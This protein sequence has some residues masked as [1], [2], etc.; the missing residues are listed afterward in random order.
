MQDKILKLLS[1]RYFL[2][3]EKT[4]DDIAKRISA[5]YPES[6]EYIKNMEFI[7]SSPTIM[8]LNT[9][10]ERKGTLSSC[11]PMDIEDSIE[12]IMEAMKECALVT[13]AGGGCGYPWSKL[14]GHIELVKGVNANSS[15]VLPF[16]QIFDSVLDGIL[17]G[18]KRRG[19]GSSLLSIYH[20]DILKFIDAKKDIKKFNRSNFSIDI[21]DL[22]YKILKNNPDKTFKIRTVVDEKEYDLKDENGKIYSYKDLW[23]K[24]I[25]SAW[26]CAEPGIFNGSIAFNRCTCTNINKMVVP[27]PCFEFCH[28][29]Y[30]SCNLGS[31]NVSKLVTVN[32]FVNFD[33]DKFKKIIDMA[34]VYLNK[35]I[36]NNTFPIDKIKDVT[37]KSRPIGL[38]L[39]GLSHLFY[40][41][42]ISYDSEK[43]EDFTK[44]MIRYMTLESMLVSVEKAKNKGKAYEYFDYN[45]FMSANERFFTKDKCREIDVEQLKRDI[46]KYGCY[47]SSQTSIAPTGSISF[48]AD[49]SSGIEPVFAL[50]YTRKIEK[51][52][53]EYEIVTICDSIFEE[54][55]T[56]NYLH[57]KDKILEYVSKNNGSCKGCNEL[58]KSVQDIFV[59]AGNIDKEWHLKILAAVANNVSLSV[60]KTI[61]LPSDATK[62]QIADIYIKAH[63]MGIIGVTVYRDGCREGILNHI[64]GGI[65]PESV[66]RHN[67][68]K[69]PEKL[70]CD[71]HEIRVEGEQYLVMVGFLNG[72][73]YEMFVTKD[74]KF[75]KL[76]GHTTGIIKKIKDKNKKDKMTYYNLIVNDSEKDEEKTV[77]KN[78][79]KVSKSIYGSLSRAISTELR[80][81][82]PL[83]I[84]VDQLNK[85][86]GFTEFD[87]IVSRILK[88][89]I[90]EGEEVLT[91][92]VCPECGGKLRYHDGCK[93][94]PCGWWKCG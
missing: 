24:I 31:I 37:K 78:I 60:S 80:H 42:N 91:S 73:I 72:T 92:E 22:F 36:D 45:T 63:E 52:N 9:K 47:N 38:G 25:D 68:P 4:W 82:V 2:K 83:Q 13:K 89:Y 8:N 81:G 7:P 28:I 46:K 20:S 18:G 71:I 17:Q 70:P 66:Q 43:A 10:G 23:N 55:I 35:I 84:V 26:L 53:K 59:V 64:D 77:I 75:I 69:R 67:A 86:E 6:Y 49:C 19:A 34:T 88:H 27:N 62:R 11:F 61:N 94:C 90:K 56:N 54:Y 87:K 50:A 41:L 33:W 51:L 74:Y 12:G 48:L 76:E 39:M 3:N 85:T 32:G 40:K 79:G 93:S 1:E 65:K 21:D 44:E 30:N 14:R 16:I 58:P 5:I 15:G 57:E 29:P